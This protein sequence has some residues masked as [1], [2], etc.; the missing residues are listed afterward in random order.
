MSQATADFDSLKI[1]YQ[2]T[3]KLTVLKPVFQIK[4]ILFFI[5]HTR[6]KL[7][8]VFFLLDIILYTNDN[9]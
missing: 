6:H 4:N 7:K 5:K 8:I 1:I 3:K 9:L 2:K